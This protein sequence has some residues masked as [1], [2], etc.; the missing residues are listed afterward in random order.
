[1][2]LTGTYGIVAA[3]G[4]ASGGRHDA[5][6]AESTLQSSRAR[7]QAAYDKATTDLTALKPTRPLAELEA[8]ASASPPCRIVVTTGNRQT[9]CAH[10]PKLL[11]E[12][13]VARR[14]AELEQK[15]EAARGELSAAPIRQANSDAAALAGY[16]AA[17]GWSV[18]PDTLNKVLALLAVLVIELGGGASL[19]I[20]MALGERMATSGAFREGFGPTTSGAAET[21]RHTVPAGQAVPTPPRPSPKPRS[22]ARDRLLELLAGANGQ[23]RVGQEALGVSIGVTSARVRQLLKELSAAG[24][25]RVRTSSTGTVISLL[26]SHDRVSVH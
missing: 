2:I 22:S 25:V 17:L 12:L 19:A 6:A 21:D 3:L 14:R 13:G 18:Q 9:V 4:S 23:L 20:G 8:L 16:L 26:G 5:A 15:V 10:P 1:M 24:V 7:T 11:A